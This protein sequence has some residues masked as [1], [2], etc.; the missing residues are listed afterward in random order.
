MGRWAIAVWLLLMAVVVLSADLLIGTPG[1]EQI[2]NLSHMPEATKVFDINGRLAFTVF[3]ERRI[4]VRLR[5][6]PR[7]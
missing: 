4:G 3:K 1:P 5:T 6:F 2:R 7:T